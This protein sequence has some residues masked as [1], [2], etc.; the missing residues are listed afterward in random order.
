M[1]FEKVD[2]N[3]VHIIPY[4]YDFSKYTEPSNESIQNIKDKYPAKLRIIMVAR[5]IPFKRHILIFPVFKK[6]IEEGFDLKILILDEGPEKENLENYIQSNGLQ[7]HLFMIGFTKKFL[8]YMKA[9]DILIHPSITEASNSVVKE[10]GLQEKPV[11]VC[12]GVGDFDDYIIDGENGFLLNISKPEIDV[13]KLI[14]KVYDQP[15][16][17]Q[18]MG[19]NLKSTVQSKFSKIEPILEQYADLIKSI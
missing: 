7:N 18:K 12:K 19:T 4:I 5:L 10:I 17:L 16:T 1:E 6:L 8:A 3:K 14:R 15:E 2:R 9:S 13:E 11:A